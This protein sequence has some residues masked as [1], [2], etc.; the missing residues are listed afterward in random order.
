MVGSV[1][2]IRVKN[3]YIYVMVMI[4]YIEMCFVL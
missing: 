1:G 4:L 2:R 3:Q